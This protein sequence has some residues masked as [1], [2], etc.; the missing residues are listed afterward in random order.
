MHFLLKILIFVSL[1]CNFYFVMGQVGTYVPPTDTLVKQKLENWLDM[2]FGLLMHW[3]LYSQLGV[4][5]SWG[6][7][8][9]DQDFQSRNGMDYIDYKNH[10]FN[11]I[12]KF[13]PQ[14]FNPDAWAEVAQ[15]AGMK[16]VVFTTKHHDGFC[17]FDTKQTDFKITSGESP[18]NSNPKANVAKY[19]FEAFRNKGFMVGAYFSK[20]D[21]HCP[22][23]WT[24][25]LATPDRNCNYDTRKYPGRWKEFQNYT[26]NQIE[27]LT[28]EYGKLDILWLDGGWVRPDSTI[29]EEVRSW[30][31]NIPKYEQDIDMPRIA[32]MARENQPGI[33]IVDRTVHGPFED[34]RTPEQSVPNSILSYPFETCMTMTSNWGYVPN[35]EYKSAELLI[36]M[37]I[38]VVSKGGNFLLNVAPTAQG[39][40][41][42]KAIL[43]LYEIGKWMSVNESAIYGSRPWKQFK[44]GNHVRF[45]QSKDGKYLYVF[46]LYWPGKSLSLPCITEKKKYKVTM[47]GSK[48]KIK[49]S[50][51]QDGL[52]LI[53]PE[54]L[55]NAA[56]R[57]T[58]Y[59]SV[60]RIT[61][62]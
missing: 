20:P 60:F 46:A 36:A 44:E 6:L 62:K 23:Y 33:L 14:Q 32:A 55:Q 41:E 54:V 11:Q 17:M 31:Y 61:L 59:I 8:S 47:L 58:A 19:V 45:T 35:A 28:T 15:K 4:V 9:E 18:F 42:N 38:D 50:F 10:Y 7:C 22:S 26:F 29:N 57:P 27:E 12:K 1:F 40:F 52:T 30:G 34:Y 21:W 51:S 48:E 24:P 37:M 49:T 25:L 56:S 43:T 13:N 53:I 16:Y 5:E 3:G 39:T 2:K